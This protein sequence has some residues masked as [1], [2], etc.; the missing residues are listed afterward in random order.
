MQDTE[1]PMAGALLHYG[2]QAQRD[3]RYVLD[4]AAWSRQDC[5]AG[6]LAGH[7][8]LAFESWT[9]NLRTVLDMSHDDP[10][11]AACR[12]ALAQLGFEF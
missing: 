7:V 11:F 2:T 4:R 3:A 8:A 6:P 1:R 9:L 12:A 10:R 5:G